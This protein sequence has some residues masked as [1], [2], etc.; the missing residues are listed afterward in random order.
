VSQAII[1][2]L[3]ARH[4]RAGGASPARSERAL[5]L[6]SG[7]RLG[8]A[9]LGATSGLPIVYLHGFLGSR[10]EVAAAE[11]LRAR[12][13]GIDRPG[14]GWSD[15]QARPSLA[16]FGR[17]LAE[18]L[19]RM[20]IEDCA[21]IG[22]SSGAPYAVAAALA[23]GRR[24]RRLVLIAG[25]ACPEL[26]A[27][28]G[29]KAS[30]L[31]RL[32]R[33]GSGEALLRRQALRLTRLCGGDR[34]LVRLAVEVESARLTRLG[35]ETEAVRTRLLRS[36]RTGSTA[37]MR[38]PIADGRLL[39]RPWDVDPAALTVPTL[40]LHG[41]A[42]EVVPVDHAHWY[43]ERIPGARLRILEDEMHLSACFCAAQLVQDEVVGAASAL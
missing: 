8:V 11:P 28:A 9:E 26:L 18:G 41:S 35:Y 2:P 40:V 39:S 24:A 14:Y 12:L 13:L 34:G 33:D 25:L 3:P 31:Q 30:Y 29:G 10:L 15:T 17:D 23:L 19:G 6:Q 4:E 20:G 38:G 37:A 21:I 5:R 36:L 22:A 1:G 27:A 32:G 42:D 7:R 16:D 43:A